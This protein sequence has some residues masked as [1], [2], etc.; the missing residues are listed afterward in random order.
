MKDPSSRRILDFLLNK[1]PE[2]RT[3]GSWGALKGHS[4]FE[5]FD[6]DKIM[7]K[8]YEP[9]YVP[10][11]EEAISD[12]QIKALEEKNKNISFRDMMIKQSI[13]SEKTKSYRKTKS[14]VNIDP[15][16]EKD[17]EY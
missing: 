15:N 17:F 14:T 2:A 6:W 13:N 12:Q 16:W 5:N 7:E 10:A 11:G 4:F 3:Q 8:R 9:P 1:S